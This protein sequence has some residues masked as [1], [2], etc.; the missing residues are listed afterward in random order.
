MRIARRSTAKR[1]YSS[2]TTNDGPHI[3]R[4]KRPDTKKPSDQTKTNYNLPDRV[5]EPCDGDRGLSKSSTPR[6]VITTVDLSAREKPEEQ[7]NS[8][9][10]QLSVGIPTRGVQ[11]VRICKNASNPPKDLVTPSSKQKLPSAGTWSIIFPRGGS[12]PARVDKEDI[13]KLDEG[14]WLNDNL[15]Q[16]YLRW[17]QDRLTTDNPDLAKRIY[18]HNTFFYEKLAKPK[19]GK[20]GI[21][22]D[23]VK[24]WTAKVDLISS[25]YII[26][27]INEHSNHWYVAIICNP[28]SLLN[29]EPIIIEDSQ[30]QD[31]ASWGDQNK[32]TGT[33]AKSSPALSTAFL[34]AG[35]AVNSEM[36]EISKAQKPLKDRVCKEWHSTDPI[37]VRLTENTLNSDAPVTFDLAQT[38]T[39]QSPPPK[40]LK[41]KDAIPVSHEY[42]ATK[43]RIITLDSIKG[44]HPQACAHLT[45]YLAAE[46]KSKRVLDIPPP[47]SLG[48]AATNIP[49][50]DNYDDC[51]PFLLI[52]IQKFLENPD[53]FVLGV[54]QKR[55]NFNIQWPN[56]SDMRNTIRDILMDLQLEQLAATRKVQQ[57]EAEGIQL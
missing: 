39:N 45:D 21:N 17:L 32:A 4:L 18:F 9:G 10:I 50:Q 36:D 5:A 1:T 12:K 23:A 24:R 52:Y 49:Q 44:K 13:P 47:G 40:K 42:P 16:F 6:E 38:S 31:K 46:I 55:F 15:I 3:H 35:P 53:E 54:L 30:S 27:P 29:L 33:A 7:A 57:E 11:R 2:C 34:T 14:N 25:K 37:L 48:V 8:E 26:V 56:P 20:R 19:K 43:T 28:S 51:G 22:Y 41:T